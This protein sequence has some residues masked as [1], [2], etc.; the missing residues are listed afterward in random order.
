MRHITPQC[1]GERDLGPF[2]PAPGTYPGRGGFK[3]DYF[4]GK[5]QTNMAGLRQA[6]P[7]HLES[8]QC[9]IS[10]PYAWERLTLGHFDPFQAPIQGPRGPKIVSRMRSVPDRAVVLMYIQADASAT[11]KCQ[12]PWTTTTKSTTPDGILL[13]ISKAYFLPCW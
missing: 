2:S 1:M 11:S 7:S 3:N 5:N 6:S 13:W 8:V 12:S 9:A 10:H 4:Y